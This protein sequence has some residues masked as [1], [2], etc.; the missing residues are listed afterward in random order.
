[1]VVGGEMTEER[2]GWRKSY[3]TKMKRIKRRSCTVQATVMY[4]LAEGDG[5]VSEVY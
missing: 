1:V 5:G 2:E 3:K 4:S